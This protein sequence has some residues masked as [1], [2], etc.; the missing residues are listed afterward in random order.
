MCGFVLLLFI[1]M[2]V[3]VGKKVG[4]FW[5]IWFLLFIVVCVW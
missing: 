3:R 4:W 2:C 5:S 1:W